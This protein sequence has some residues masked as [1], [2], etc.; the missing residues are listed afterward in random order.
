MGTGLTSPHRSVLPQKNFASNYSRS[1]PPAASSR[2]PRLPPITNH[3]SLLTSHY[4]R[5]PAC[6]MTLSASF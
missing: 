6:F 5:Y 3:Q 1:R 2:A 4:L